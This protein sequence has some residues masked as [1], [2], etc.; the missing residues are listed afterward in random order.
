MDQFVKMFGPQKYEAANKTLYNP[1][2]P[3]DQKPIGPQ[4]EGKTKLPSSAKM[5][6]KDTS[7]STGWRYKLF[8]NESG[9]YDIAA[10]EAPK[11][12][13]SKVQQ[14][15]FVDE[16][17][18]PLIFDPD[19]ETYRVANT[20]TKVYPKKKSLTSEITDNMGGGITYLQQ[21]DKIEKTYNDALAGPASGNINKASGMVINN[22]E[23]QGLRL[24]VGTLRTVVYQLSGKQ[25]NE[26]EQ[27]WLEN[28]ILPSLTQPNENFKAKL[29]ELKSW[30]KTKLKNQVETFG[31]SYIIPKN[32]EDYL[33]NSDGKKIGRF[34]IE[35]Q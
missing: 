12:Y 23:F 13:A 26:S 27:K 30:M 22:P 29:T 8:N 28:D 34:T 4:D 6:V 19:N 15:S 25:I 11:S 32:V 18:N 21:I 5:V 24:D 33:K 31:T 20:G 1:M 17:N 14:T 10:D 35:E 7:S 3:T 9:R 16:D 2:D